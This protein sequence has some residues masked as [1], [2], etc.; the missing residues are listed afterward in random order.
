MILTI[1]NGRCP[2]SAKCTGLQERTQIRKSVHSNEC[3]WRDSN[4]SNS[5]FEPGIIYFPNSTMSAGNQ[6]Q[7]QIS[8]ANLSNIETICHNVTARALHWALCS[9]GFE[10]FLGNNLQPKTETERETERESVQWISCKFY[11]WRGA[12][13][14]NL[15]WQGGLTEVCLEDKVREG[16]CELSLNNSNYRW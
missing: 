15:A 12:E 2:S 16:N 6:T 8:A 9:P 11:M 14:A 5:K 4:C 10:A 7:A 1:I 13:R 3:K